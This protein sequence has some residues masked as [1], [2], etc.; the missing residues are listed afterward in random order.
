MIAYSSTR[1]ASRSPPPGVP[2]STNACAATQV[3]PCRRRT[4]RTARRSRAA[5]ARRRPGRA[6][7]PRCAIRCSARTMP[8]L[9]TNGS[10]ARRT[11][12]PSR[13]VI[14]RTPPS[15]GRPGSATSGPGRARAGARPPAGG[16]RC[17]GCRRSPPPCGARCG[18]GEQRAVDDRP[19]P[20]RSA[21]P[22][23][24]RSPATTTRSTSCSAGDRRRSRRARPGARRPG[25][26][27]G[28]ALPTCQSEVCSSFIAPVHAAR[29]TGRRRCVVALVGAG[30]RGRPRPSGSPTPGTG[31]RPAAAPAAG[32][33]TRYIEPGLRI[34]ARWRWT[35]GRNPYSLAAGL[36]RVEAA[37][38]PDRA[39]WRRPGARPRSRSAGRRSG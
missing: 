12:A 21:T 28:C 17:R 34:V 27:R 8:R 18:E 11:S 35:G 14:V 5:A 24:N 3:A 2:P 13:V 9:D 31:T 15:S 30:V 37:D 10:I 36:G 23:L 1:W 38:D 22:S 29:R 19:R 7:R 4:R 16:G 32:A 26:G 6:R 33:G 25:C 20:R 39:S